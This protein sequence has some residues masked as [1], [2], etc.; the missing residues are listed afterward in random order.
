MEADG[1]FL[2]EAGLAALLLIAI[3]LASQPHDY[4]RPEK[5]LQSQK[6]HDLLIVWAM[7]GTNIG[8]M[9]KDAALFLGGGVGF[10]IEYRGEKVVVA[11]PE[12]GADA[13]DKEAVSDEII[14]S[15]RSG[16]AE[17]IRLSI[18]G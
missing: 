17:K 2:Y 4:A 18:M 8:E 7:E 9:G 13:K 12:R 15:I 1:I 5:I 10:A 11:P 14:Y 6:L 3:I 16:A